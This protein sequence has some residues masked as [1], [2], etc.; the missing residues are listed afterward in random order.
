ME[1][2]F[3]TS[4][5][6]KKPITSSGVVS[7]EPKSLF[8]IIAIFLLVVS[9]LASV[10]LFVYKAYLTKQKESASSSLSIIRDSFEKDTIDEL[11]S[12]NKKTESAKKIL[13][14][15][16]VLSPMFSL[17]GEITIPTIQYTKFDQQNSPEGFLIKIDGLARDYR[18]IALQADMFNTVKG[19]SFKNVVFSNLVKDKNNNIIFNLEFNVDQSLL[20]YE[21][22]NLTTQTKNTNSTTSNTVTPPPTTTLPANTN[23]TPT[24]NPPVTQNPLPQD[25]NT[26]SQ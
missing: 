16:I 8:L 18:A 5:I 11:S 1:N 17:L 25:L 4:F 9:I 19:R 14:N 10:G 3:Q 12:F 2:S 20:S 21:K 24:T 15:H 23:P 26:Q 13:N 22:N 6:P 7:R